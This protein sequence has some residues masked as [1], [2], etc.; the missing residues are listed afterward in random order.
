MCV[1][2]VVSII[3]AEN[4]FF[5]VPSLCTT[6][7]SDKT[8]III[9]GVFTTIIY[10]SALINITMINC[11]PKHMHVVTRK[12]KEKDLSMV[13]QHQTTLL[14]KRFFKKITEGNLNQ[15][16]L[17]LYKRSFICFFS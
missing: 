17:V 7:L 10:S 2:R 12:I 1:L 15:G 9:D 14:R 4:H 5:P 3:V 11:A 13:N 16:P 6:I 8:Y